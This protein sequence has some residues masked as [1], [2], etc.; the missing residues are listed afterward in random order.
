M[1]QFVS[2]S[3]PLYGFQGLFVACQLRIK[4]HRALLD[5]AFVQIV[6]LSPAE[7]GCLDIFELCRER[8][9]LGGVHGVVLVVYQTAAGP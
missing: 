1:S 3:S 6:R 5:E 8:M 7:T 4:I 2:I 9:F